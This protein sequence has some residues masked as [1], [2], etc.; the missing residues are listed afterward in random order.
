[1]FDAAE[2]LAKRYAERHSRDV[3]DV[4]PLFGLLAETA[5]TGTLNNQ[6][7]ADLVRIEELEPEG[8][9]RLLKSV[10]RF[11]TGEGPVSAEARSALLRKLDLQGVQIAVDLI[12]EGARS[13]GDIN[14][15]ISGLSGIDRLRT[16]VREVFAERGQ[17]LR[18]LWAAET[19]RR[20]S[21]RPGVPPAFAQALRDMTER[22]R[23][24]ERMH[25]L[26]EMEAF[27]QLCEGKIML[28]PNLE[29]DLRRLALNRDPVLRLAAENDS[30]DALRNAALAGVARW[31]AV[32]MNPKAANDDVARTVI[33]SYTLALAAIQ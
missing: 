17:L 3:A 12:R 20:I 11:R 30:A 10:D 1:V 15:K 27:D 18:L 7:A 33:R 16:R 21:Y 6:D 31:R 2:T 24:D 22:I 28:S 13:A 25:G 26:R 32:R 9:R 23:F 4:L 19:L 14:R 8:Q 29:E 5:E